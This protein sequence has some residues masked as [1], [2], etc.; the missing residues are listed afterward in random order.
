MF[1]NASNRN[2]Y[3]F[4]YKTGFVSIG[5]TEKNPLTRKRER[6]FSFGKGLF[7]VSTFTFDLRKYVSI[8]HYLIISITLV[9]CSKFTVA[10]KNSDTNLNGTIVRPS[11]ICAGTSIPGAN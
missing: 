9:A 5:Y 10:P 8:I 11:I 7:C 6:I 4:G 2:T 1:I 3:E